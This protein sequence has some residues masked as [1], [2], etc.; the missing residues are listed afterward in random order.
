MILASTSCFDGVRL[1][2]P[3]AQKRS[4]DATD[5]PTVLVLG[6]GDTGVLTA[7]HLPRG[8][9]VVG[10]TTKPMLV[11]G[12]E[13]GQRLSDQDNWRRDYLLP[14][15]KFRRLGRVEIIHGR[16][17]VVDPDHRT[18]TVATA[19]GDERHLAWDYLI[20][21][22]GVSNGFWRDDRVETAASIER[23]LS[24]QVASVEAAGSIAVVGG[25]PCGTS[26]AFNLK[27]AYPEKKVTLY[28]SGLLPLPGY[29]DE[30]RHYHRDALRQ[31]G[32]L[33]VTNRRVVLPA[34]EA[35][36]QLT[37]GRLQFEDESPE[38]RA[39]LI[40]WTAGQLRPHTNFLPDHMLDER[41]FVLTDAHLNARGY[42]R[43]FAI[44]DV[45]ATDPLRCSARNWAYR[46]LCRNV[47]ACLDNRVPTAVF[48]PP[49]ARWGSVLGVQP[50]GLKL[51]GPQGKRRRLPRS[52]VRR[53]LY[54]FIVRRWIY[55]GTTDGP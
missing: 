13:L 52:F 46:T 10:V 50:E 5:C 9:R 20:I 4:D 55:G 44:G 17:T 31:Q 38:V 14:L 18:A 36:A 32:V 47:A 11:S 27:R 33:L 39:D 41:G 1:P 40:I 2:L 21:A 28:V 45:A 24:A 53:F 8:C 6:M 29:A 48:T 3:T 25:G 34:T 16:V 54:P 12:Q 19:A 15:A 22:T 23:R 37:G 43:I 51:H 49:A 7:A 30:T 26:T 35:Q 42:S